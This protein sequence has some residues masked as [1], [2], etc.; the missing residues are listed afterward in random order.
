MSATKG[1]ISILRMTPGVLFIVSVDFFDNFFDAFEY[2]L[3]LQD[4]FSRIYE[5]NVCAALGMQIVLESSPCFPYSAFQEVSFYCP[6]EK[7]LRYGN[8]DSVDRFL[9]SCAV[10]EPDR[11]G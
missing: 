10:Y 6:F 2:L 11:P 8:Q 7:F 4:F 9:R 1:K 3:I 5:E